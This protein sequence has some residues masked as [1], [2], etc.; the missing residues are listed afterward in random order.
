MRRP[1]VFLDRDGVINVDRQDY[2]RSWDQF[3]FERGALEALGELA[4]GPAPIVVVTNQ[5]CVGKG[6]VSPET[7][8]DVHRRM[9]EAVAAAGGRLDAVY[10]CTHAPADGCAC[11]KPRPGLLLTAAE[12][13]GLDLG[14]SWFVG[15]SARDLQAAAAAGVRSVLVLTG[16]GAE[17]AEGE[18]AQ[19]SAVLP[20]LPEAVRFLRGA[21]AAGAR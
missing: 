21:G 12:E 20:D 19:A 6:L 1:A 7:L 9:R 18:R 2:V 14:A 13:L 16:H 11:R 10:C 15:D 5:A 4:R 17:V 8:A 3:A